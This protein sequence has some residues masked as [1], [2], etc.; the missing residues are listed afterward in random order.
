M[1]ETKLKPCLLCNYDG[2]ILYDASHVEME[3][4]GV[5]EPCIYCPDCGLTIYFPEEY[6]DKLIKAWNT[7]H[8]GDV[9]GDGEIDAA[10]PLEIGKFM[11]KANDKYNEMQTNKRIGAKWIKQQTKPTMSELT[12]ERLCVFCNEICEDAPTERGWAEVP[13]NKG[14]HFDCARKIA[15]IVDMP[16]DEEINK[17]AFRYSGLDKKAMLLKPIPENAKLIWAFNAGAKWGIE[18]MKGK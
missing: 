4:D 18:Q 10:F 12:D 9:P 17:A 2:V 6:K 16:R 8:V 15:G 7:R 11:F 3:E 14:L 5:G 1:E 13:Y